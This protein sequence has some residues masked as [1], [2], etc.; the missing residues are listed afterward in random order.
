[1][2]LSGTSPRWNKPCYQNFL[3]VGMPPKDLWVDITQAWLRQGLNIDDCWKRACSVTNEWVY[4]ANST[5]ELKSRIR[6]R[7][8]PQNDM[9]I[10]LKNR[11]LAEV[12]DPQPEASVVIKKFLDWIDRVDVASQEGLPKPIFEA[13]DGS[14]IFPDGEETW[15]HSCTPSSVVCRHRSRHHRIAATHRSIL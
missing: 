14:P 15:S 7:R 3:L 12:L 13:A 1:M 2:K 9:C 4:E 6:Q 11:T 8:M 5:L 10:P